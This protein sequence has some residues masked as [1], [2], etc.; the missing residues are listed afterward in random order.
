MN[1][2][3]V[4]A[5]AFSCVALSGVPRVIGAG[6]AHVRVG[7]GGDTICKYPEPPPE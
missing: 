2:P 3:G 7:V 6:V 5:V 1:V 4:F